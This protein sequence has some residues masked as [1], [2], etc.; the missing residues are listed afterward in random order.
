MVQQGIVG[1]WKEAFNADYTTIKDVNTDQMDQLNS[2]QEAFNNV[3]RLVAER[4]DVASPYY[5]TI[6]QFLLASQA[7]TDQA[8]LFTRT[9]RH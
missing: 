2:V 8:I 5:A 3:G 6:M 4:I 7:L 9:T 1:P